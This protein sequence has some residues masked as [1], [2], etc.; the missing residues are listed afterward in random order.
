MIHDCEK[1]KT[2]PILLD[3]KPQTFDIELA[4][5]DVN[6]MAH[7]CTEHGVCI[8]INIGKEQPVPAYHN[9]LLQN[10][11]PKKNHA[12]PTDVV[13]NFQSPTWKTFWGIFGFSQWWHYIVV[14][15]ISIV[16]I[17]LLILIFKFGTPLLYVIRWM[18][19]KK[20]QTSNDER[21]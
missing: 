13:L 14:I 6:A 12:I 18:F 3:A 20:M 10:P 1:I 16:G 2:V 19:K 5:Y 21:D 17:I 7:I 15:G 11:A 4:N 8:E 9:I